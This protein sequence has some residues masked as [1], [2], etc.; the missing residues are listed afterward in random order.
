[1]SSLRRK[2]VE[3]GALPVGE[4]TCDV[5]MFYLLTSDLT[6]IMTYLFWIRQPFW[7]AFSLVFS[8]LGPLPTLNMDQG[9]TNCTTKARPT[10][11]KTPTIYMIHALRSKL[12]QDKLLEVF[13]HDSY[14][15]Q[16]VP[17]ES[18]MYWVLST[19][20]LSTRRTQEAYRSTHDFFAIDLEHAHIRPNFHWI[21]WSVGE[22]TSD[23]C[24]KLYVE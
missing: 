17:R 23:F 16:K 3:V 24:W 10:V 12:Y 19:R 6:S 20:L 13:T 9:K 1:M 14:V 4:A 21:F 22:M 5:Y 18:T 2:C 7:H 15:G 11:R 8:V